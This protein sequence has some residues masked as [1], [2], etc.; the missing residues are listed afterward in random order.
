MRLCSDARPGLV[1]RVL[2]QIVEMEL[3]GRRTSRCHTTSPT[4]CAEKQ[5]NHTKLNPK[6]NAKVSAPAVRHARSTSRHV[7]RAR[8]RQR[9]AS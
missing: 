7:R 2:A 5:R 8:R 1:T 6:R 9:K 3:V 4:P